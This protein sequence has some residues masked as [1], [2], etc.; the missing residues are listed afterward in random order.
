[1]AE[2][3][4]A[5][6]VAL[7]YHKAL[8]TEIIE[9]LK[10]RDN[11]LL[12][13]LGASGA[14]LGYGMKEGKFVNSLLIILPFLALGAAAI[15]IQ[16]QDQII[17]IYEYLTLELVKHL[18]E[19]GKRV[20]TFNES[21]AASEHFR[22]NISMG[23]LAQ[24]LLICGPPV[25]AIVVNLADSPGPWTRAADTYLILGIVLNGITVGWLW[26]SMRY[27]SVTMSRLSRQK[28]VR[29]QRTFRFER[30]LVERELNEDRYGVRQPCCRFL[31]AGCP[32]LCSLHL[33]PIPTPDQ[34]MLVR[35]GW[36]PVGSD[37][38]R[39]LQESHVPFWE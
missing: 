20:I 37:K 27:R 36:H 17:G 33:C 7:E 13:Y 31:C 4:E 3:N 11:A 34:L 16:H 29:P 12:A 1:M 8:R 25:F 30:A 35:V 19:G 39:S 6:H 5:T 32:S 24:I 18:P 9:R 10:M 2:P 38:G 23:F 28:E 22:P 21:K 15:I 14:L 26:S